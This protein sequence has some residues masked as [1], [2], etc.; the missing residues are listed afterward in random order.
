[1]MAAPNQDTRNDTNGRGVQDRLIEAAED[2]FC[3]RGF[4]DTSVRDIA[5]AADCNVA[6]VNYYFG[7]K[8]SL[9][10]EIWRRRLAQ[11]HESRLA[12]IEMVMSAGGQ[13]RLEDLLRS[14]AVSFIEPLIE[15]DRQC[16]FVNLM[17]RE[18]IDPHLPREVFLAEM[19]KPVLSALSKALMEICPW[20]NEANAQVAILLMV[21][22]LIH[23]VCAKELF[24]ESSHGEPFQL[25]LENL[26]EHIVKFSAAGIRAYANQETT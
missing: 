10:L 26:V 7:G 19:V 18:M 4:N 6:S 5:A 21:G 8:D 3:R 23:A 1:M 2:L 16:R 11:M 25:E 24:E 20:L 14:H 15:G 22:Q 12:S 13:P 17:A 9:Y